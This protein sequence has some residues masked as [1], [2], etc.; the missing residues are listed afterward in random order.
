MSSTERGRGVS[1]SGRAVPS[2]HKTPVS[3]GV[4]GNILHDEEV[5]LRRLPVRLY[6]VRFLGRTV[7]DM[8]TDAPTPH[9]RKTMHRDRMVLLARADGMSI[10]QI[11]WALDMSTSTVWKMLRR[12]EQ[13]QEQQS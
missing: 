2:V 6:R 7:V 1:R 5:W 12:I 13:E 8:S 11:A 4:R 3:T 10:Q 9:K